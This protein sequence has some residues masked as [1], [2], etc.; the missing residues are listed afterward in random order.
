MAEDDRRIVKITLDEHTVVRRSADI[1]HERA[2]AIFDLLEENSFIPAGGAA[3]PY[4]L[5]LTMEGPRLVLEIRTADG[6]A[7][8][9]V[10]LA[11]AEFRSIIKDYFLICESYNHAI[12]NAPLSKITAIDH[13]RRAL[14]D[15]ASELLRERLAPQVAVDFNTARRL[16]T[17]ICVLQIRG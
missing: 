14:H 9:R 17:L 3:G 1:E 2:T 4:H 7:L 5:H 13:G 12:R 11:V 16:F 8:D 6:T 10:A 15:E